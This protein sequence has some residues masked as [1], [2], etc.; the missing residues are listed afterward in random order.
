MKKKTKIGLTCAVAVA[1]GVLAYSH[2]V[3]PKQLQLKEYQINTNKNKT[4]R[5]IL[6]GDLH[7]DNST[8]M[9]YL[10]KVVDMINQ[11]NPDLVLF[12]G[13]FFDA[14]HRYHGN[15][16]DVIQVMSLVKS[17]YGNFAVFG[18]HDVGGGSIRIYPEV[19]EKSGFKMILNNN[20]LIEEIG[21]NLIGLDDSM[22]GNPLSSINMLKEEQ[23]M[24]ILMTHEPDIVDNYNLQN[25]SLV[26][27]GHTHGGQVS[28]P[29]VSNFVLPKYGKKYVDGIYEL[30]DESKII[31]TSGIGTTHL[32]MRLANPPEIVLIQTK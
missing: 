25:V 5:I 16:D 30:S 27:S 6:F 7:I 9:N 4:L 14:F 22:L 32:A 3:E 23:A 2:F 1:S 24:N 28:L 26:A 12:T 13:D 10:K 11:Q 21:V 15:V 31:V 8:S 18:N 29:I 17:K 19:M 20:V